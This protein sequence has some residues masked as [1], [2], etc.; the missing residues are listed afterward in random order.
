MGE[1]FRDNEEKI[2][3]GMI[4]VGVTI[5]VILMTALIVYLSS[6]SREDEIRTSAINN[7]EKNLTNSSESASTTIGKTVDEVLNELETEEVENITSKVDVKKTETENIMSTN[8]NSVLEEN[9]T[10]ENEIQEEEP[11]EIKFVAP[12]K[13]EILRDFAPDSLVYSDTLEEWITH[14]GVDIKA[15]K[16]S[17][18]V[19]SSARKSFCNKK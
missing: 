4:V 1:H 16:T 14:N 15:D 5:I 2:T 11:K 17:V 8:T 7:T 12:I 19:A 13:G 18:V 10:D 6:D 3:L 9:S